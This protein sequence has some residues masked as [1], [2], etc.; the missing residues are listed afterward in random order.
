MNI[1]LWWQNRL[2][3]KQAELEKAKEV[4]VGS[5]IDK[6]KSITC[7][8]DLVAQIS[9]L[10]RNLAR[11]GEAHITQKL[12]DL[13][14][15][16]HGD[17]GEYTHEFGLVASFEEAVK[18]IHRMRTELDGTTLKRILNVDSLENI[19]VAGTLSSPQAKS[20]EEAAL[21][22]PRAGLACVDGCQE[23]CVRASGDVVCEACQKPYRLHP[24]CRG[25]VTMMTGVPEYFLHVHCDGTHLK[26]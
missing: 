2:E 12:M 16:I 3:E 21:R 22:V 8:L 26:L 17:A 13:L 18:K 5:A 4:T 19:T 1:V 11:H 20:V 6:M 15:A 9:Q 7:R 25:Q 23:L 14:D 10:E 24:Y